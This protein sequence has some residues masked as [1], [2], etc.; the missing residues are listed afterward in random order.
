[1]ASSWLPL[2]LLISSL[3]LLCSGLTNRTIDDTLGDLSADTRVAYFPA[4]GWFSRVPKCVESPDHRCPPGPD[5]TQ[6][7]NGVYVLLQYCI[8]VDRPSRDLA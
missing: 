1:M 6:T 5:P 7:S 8:L 3:C 4:D 2:F